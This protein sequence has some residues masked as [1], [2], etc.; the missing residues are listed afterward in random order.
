M[1]IAPDMSAIPTKRLVDIYNTITGK[2]IKKF[3]TRQRGEMQVG[4][5]LAQDQCN[6]VMDEEGNLKVRAGKEERPMDNPPRL[7]PEAVYPEDRDPV[8]TPDKKPT[9]PKTYAGGRR[10]RTVLSDEE[11]LE[12]TG[13]N[14]GIGKKIHTEIN[15]AFDGKRTVSEVVEH[16]KSTLNP[17]RAKGWQEDPDKYLREY[18]SYN[19]GK[20]ALRRRV[21][22]GAD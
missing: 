18:I 20:G 13:D 9:A 3:S 11:V 6:Y 5:A 21:D 15:N 14:S 7:D 12:Q 19:I 1:F 16:L 10:V 2:S 22:D 17:P 8:E 4:H